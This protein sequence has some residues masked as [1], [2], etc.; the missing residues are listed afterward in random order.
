MKEM[1]GG[2]GAV[3]GCLLLSQH[4]MV[5]AVS[6]AG[7]PYKVWVYKVDSAVGGAREGML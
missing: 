4:F 1:L 2:R 3:G 6:V 5:F 7:A